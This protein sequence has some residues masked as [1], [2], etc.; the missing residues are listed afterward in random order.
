MMERKLVSF[1][2]DSKYKDEKY[3]LDDNIKMN[4]SSTDWL[5]SSF[6]DVTEGGIVFL[7]SQLCV[8]GYVQYKEIDYVHFSMCTRYAGGFGNASRFGG[9]HVDINIDLNIRLKDDEIVLEISKPTSLSDLIEQLQNHNIECID[10][11][12]VIEI[13][14]Q[15][16]SA[17]RR[18]KYLQANI[19]KM[20]KKY[21]LDHPR[22]K[23]KFK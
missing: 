13:Y 1:F 23:S 10:M 18:E 7:N 15:Y 17:D 6:I 20:A 21:H 16:P 9:I 3:V 22:F 8:I 5:L 14:K 11:I 2:K 12:G 19:N 4:H